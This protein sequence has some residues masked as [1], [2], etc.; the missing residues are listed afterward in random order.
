[1]LFVKYFV[2]NIFLA[3]VFGV[4]EG[5]FFIKNQAKSMYS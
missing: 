4:F 1:M 5:V 2:K 3:T